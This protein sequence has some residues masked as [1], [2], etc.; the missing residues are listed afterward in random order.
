MAIGLMIRNIVK[1]KLDQSPHEPVWCRTNSLVCSAS[2]TCAC[3]SCP[4]TVRWCDCQT[5]PDARVVWCWETSLCW[6]VRPLSGSTRI[7][8]PIWSCPCA[9]ANAAGTVGAYC[10]SVSPCHSVQ[11]T[12]CNRHGKAPIGLSSCSCAGACCSQHRWGMYCKLPESG[13]WQVCK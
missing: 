9:L 7:R 12:H 13:L 8:E 11:P 4:I 5:S 6:N 2:S 3:C 1:K 10:A